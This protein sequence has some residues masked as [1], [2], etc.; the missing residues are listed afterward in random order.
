MLYLE[1]TII[2]TQEGLCNQL[3]SVFRT[4]GESLFYRGIGF[5]TCV[6]LSKAYTRTSVNF[7]SPP[8]FTEIPIDLF[9][10]MTDLTNVLNSI[11]IRLIRS[12]A[13]IVSPCQGIIECWR[14]PLRDMTELEHRILGQFIAHHFP[15]AKRALSLAHFIVQVISSV[16]PKW[17]AIHYR[18]EKDLLVM[19]PPEVL[20]LHK[21][22][23]MESTLATIHN[24][25]D[26]SAIYLACGLQEQ[27]YDN[28]VKQIK[29]HY[30]KLEVFNKRHVLKGFPEVE[31]Q[32][33]Q[34]TLEEQALV[35]WVVCQTAPSFSGWYNS[36]FSYLAAYIRHYRGV[37]PTTT[38]LGPETTGIWD[39]WFPRI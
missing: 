12:R 7:D 23:Q 3:M 38:K 29:Q 14:P 13:E 6:I 4:I 25:Q 10:D 24:T 8:Y 22:N 30:P 34:L 32:F 2:D 33:N 18:V 36:S 17:E 31:S 27:E 39:Q 16:C 11:D 1:H 19:I 37:N 26:L 35:D 5:D 28:V 21:N 20:D 9:V 15:I